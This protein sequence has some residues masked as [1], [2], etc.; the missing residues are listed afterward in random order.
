MAQAFSVAVDL[1]ELH[2]V[3]ALTRMNLFSNLAE[4]VRSVALAGVERWQRAVH[5]APLWAGERD[6]YANTIRAYQTGAL[7]WEIVSD[8]K[9]VEDI[10]G[11]RPPYDLKRM[12][13][14][15]MKVRISAKGRRYL[16]IPFR[17]NTPGNEAHARAMPLGIY[18]E[19]ADMQPSAVVGHGTRLSGTGAWDTK[20]KKPARVRARKYVWG[21]RLPAGLAP[22]LKPAHKSDPY[23]GMVRF[24]NAK[25]NGQRYSSYI[26][27]RV[28]AEGQPGWIIPSRPGLWIARNVADSLQRTAQAEFGAAVQ[29]DLASA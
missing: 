6:A 3:A 22:R 25:P 18:K 11:G 29:R 20:T 2:Q 27:F 15:S 17:H 1:S 10:E 5:A 26:T 12:L 7:A 4:S 28:M 24:T 8:Y 16:I 21:D 14:T 9:Y 19:A 13:S 23:A